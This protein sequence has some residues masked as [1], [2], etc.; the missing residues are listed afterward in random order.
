MSDPKLGPS[1][2]QIA[3]MGHNIQAQL[4][5]RAR[6]RRRRTRGLALGVGLALL[7]GGS[8]TAAA[9]AVRPAPDEQIRYLVDC[10]PT[11]AITPDDFGRV[12]FLPEEND[13]V[14]FGSEFALM[15]C[16]RAYEREQI[17]APNPTVCELADLRLGVFP[18]P[19]DIPQEQF[20]V[21]LG[22]HAPGY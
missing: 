6:R 3:M 21:A 2:A 9:L 12:L 16:L 15:Q 17:D 4:D 10:Y 7:I 5:D 11:P 13:D 8:V 20:C 1:P 19:E 18:N 22:L 14:P